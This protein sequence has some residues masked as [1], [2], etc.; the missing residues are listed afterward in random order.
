VAAMMMVMLIQC[1]KGTLAYG[2]LIVIIIIGLIAT[3]A[4]LNMK[5]A[6]ALDRGL[7]KDAQRGLEE[8]KQAE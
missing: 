1:G 4:M 7:G 2:I 8:A 5:D 3:F 6:N